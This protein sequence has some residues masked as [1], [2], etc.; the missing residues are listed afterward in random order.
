MSNLNDI[1]FSLK[2]ENNKSLTN[3]TGF[4]N[5]KYIV[6]DLKIINNEALIN[7]DAFENL[8][9][10]EGDF[11]ISSNSELENISALNNLVTIGGVL[12]I[13]KNNALISILGLD[14]ITWDSIIGEYT[15]QFYIYD[16]NSLSECNVQSICEEIA[17][18]DSDII[19]NNAPG[20]KNR[21]EVKASCEA[22]P[23]LPEGISLS[24][25][26]EIDDFQA[27]Y[28]GCT[29]IG[30]NVTIS[31]NDIESLNGLSSLD[32]V[33]GNL[34]IND[35]PSLNSLN[36][37][38]NLISVN[39][40]LRIENNVA[41]TDI[42]AIK[43]LDQAYIDSL[44]IKNNALLSSCG[45]QSICFYL[46]VPENSTEISNNAIGCNNL[47]E[48]G[49]S[50]IGDTCFAEYSIV[51]TTQSEI[52]D[53]QLNYPGCSVIDG[54]VGIQDDFGGEISNLNGLSS[55][56]GVTGDITIYRVKLLASLIGLDN[57]TYIGGSFTIG[58]TQEL[59]SFKG[60]HNL[61]YIGG[62]HFSIDYNESLSNIDDL[63]NLKYLGANLNIDHNDELRSL[64]GLNNLTLADRSIEITK[65]KKLESIEGFN[66]LDSIYSWI[67]IK[68][69]PKL[70]K[71]NGFNNLKFIGERLT[72]ENNATLSGITGFEQLNKVN[73][74]VFIWDN[75]KLIDL[76]GLHNLRSANN[77]IIWNSSSLL[78]LNGLSNL[79]TINGLGIGECDALI[80]LEGLEN[81]TSISGVAIQD[82]DELINLNGLE[83][84][85]VLKGI[86]NK[87]PVIAISNNNKLADISNLNNIKFEPYYNDFGIPEGGQIIINE[88]DSLSDISVISNIDANFISTV[89]IVDNSVLSFC[90]FPNICEFLAT[91]PDSN[92]AIEGNDE[93]CSS[94]NE[95][96]EACDLPCSPSITFAN[97]A[98]IDSF[99]I[100][101]PDCLNNPGEIII[102]GEDINNLNELSSLISIGN[103]IIRNTPLLT[104]LSGLDNLTSITNFKLENLS[105]LSN[106]D[107]LENLTSIIGRLEIFDNPVLNSLN[108]IN[109]LTSVGDLIFI[110][111]ES[112]SDL[113][114]LA[115][116]TI[117][118]N[119][120]TLNN[121]AMSDL[122]GLQSLKHAGL[123]SILNNDNLIDISDLENV[124]PASILSLNIKNNQSLASCAVRS[125]CLYL[126]ILFRNRDISD[127]A[128]GCNNLN[129]VIEA[130]PENLNGFVFTHQYQIDEFLIDNPNLSAITG[131]VYIGGGSSIINL[132]GL[133]N[134]NSIS[135]SLW[136][137]TYALTNLEGLNNLTTLIGDFYLT[138]NKVLKNVLDLENLT[139]IGGE[140][141]IIK[142]D[143]LH[144]LDGLDNINANSIS[145]LS[146]FN[147]NSLSVCNIQSI[148]E[149][150]ISPN[151]ETLISSN[152]YGCDDN[153]E[154]LDDCLGMLNKLVFTSQSAIDNFKF[155]FPELT[156]FGGDVFITGEDI[157]NVDGLNDII[158][159]GG[160]LWIG[161]SL[162]GNPLLEN[163][164]GFNNLVDLGGNLY[165][166]NNLSLRSL[167]SNKRL[168]AYNDSDDDKSEKS[169]SISFENLSSI[170]GNLWIK[171]NSNI[172][173]LSDL[174]GLTSIGGSLKIVG[175]DSLTSLVGLEDIIADSIRE[176]VITDNLILSTCAIQSIC[177]Y[178]DNPVGE[179]NI[180]NNASKCNGINEVKSE[181]KDVDHGSDFDFSIYPNP[182]TKTVF[183][184]TTNGGVVNQVIIYNQVGQK[185]IHKDYLPE[186]IDVSELSQG[187]YII[188]LSSDNKK[189]RQK[190]IIQK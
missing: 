153:K 118:A 142:N 92:T 174:S 102:E 99:Q 113:T 161:D 175:N 1:N 125:I 98:A 90:G 116:L 152:A 16:N 84:I 35:N 41:L 183:I 29:V 68:S 88:N 157:T 136:I 14:N 21:V 15:V 130:C 7:L 83:N 57:L 56:T 139:T 135:G 114:A 26:S 97:Q 122:K 171:N 106:L 160:D 2:I 180:F 51:F 150:L 145:K 66:N 55:L 62:N 75:P 28:S 144:S 189:S 10:I 168:I 78:N 89:Q 96:V 167:K 134:I 3:L 119:R 5:L 187:V 74:N 40:E 110:D 30:G 184:S 4:E 76:P 172:K 188:E 108:G 44:T 138:N 190:L 22:I 151:G 38:N 32:I 67:Y 155:N 93:G 147:N 179:I 53:F 112:L 18:S 54:N 58:V 71:V 164:S 148:C 81:I 19:A 63:Y 123:V 39:G 69:N 133:I 60:L 100:N 117:A 128:Q 87:P 165:I 31:G 143:S 159:I 131:D 17:S 36:G 141:K 162:N 80:N 166:L 13:F 127:N 64:N 20:C 177:N 163:L 43:N 33:G 95:I 115:N 65:N 154:V 82:N 9:S 45:V 170:G 59:S 149:Y 181:C 73:E 25:Q 176:L 52:D 185:I 79:E 158:S 137:S 132:D 182:A 61:E 109:N 178:L 27:N 42:Q 86:K 129:E 169:I 47:L 85:T 48:V 101:Y 37:L 23:C 49:N 50:C 140:L 70:L 72:I 6:K 94:I 124:I 146:I 24:N 126:K 107:G 111:N 8:T 120:L 77:I 103:L 104:D 46:N 173:E 34:I 186:S 91:S 11:Q 12:K 156:E 121:L 105:M